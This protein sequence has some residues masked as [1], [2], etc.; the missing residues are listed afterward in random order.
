[1]NPFKR[2]FTLTSEPTVRSEV[3]KRRMKKKMQFLL[4]KVNSYDDCQSTKRKKE[5]SWMLSALHFSFSPSLSP[6]LLFL[7][8]Y[9]RFVFLFCDVLIISL[10]I[11]YICIFMCVSF[12]EGFLQKYAIIGLHEN[13]NSQAIIDENSLA[14]WQ[15]YRIT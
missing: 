8:L 5:N 3:D 7:I 4:S 9:F 10:Y 1:M 2:I 14:N 6:S 12:D 15:R 13:Y 11:L